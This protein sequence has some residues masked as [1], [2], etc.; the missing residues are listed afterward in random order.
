MLR[1]RTPCR[2]RALR[3]L[4]V[5]VLT[6]TKAQSM[7]RVGRSSWTKNWLLQR[8]QFCHMP[9]LH[10][11]RENNPDDF[12]N[13]LRMTDPV[14]QRLLALLTPYISRQDTCMRQAITPE[15]RLVATLRYLV[16]GRSLQD[17]KFS[18]GISPQALGIIIPETCSAIIQVLQKEYMK[19]CGES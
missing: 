7:N 10:E 16:M 18:T 5:G 12:R 9:L 3:G 11:I 15:Q 14:I 17:L 6:L 8:D 19:K 13:F 1:I 2:V 4:G